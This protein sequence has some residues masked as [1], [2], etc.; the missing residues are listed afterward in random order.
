MTLFNPTTSKI[1]IV[2]D[3]NTS[4]ISISSSICTNKLEIYT[5]NMMVAW[6]SLYGGHEELVSKH[7]LKIGPTDFAS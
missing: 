5:S 2:K 3:K 1:I 4:D 7:I 6:I